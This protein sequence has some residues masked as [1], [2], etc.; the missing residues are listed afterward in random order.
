M[1]GSYWINKEERSMIAR[2]HTIDMKHR[3]SLEIAESI[4]RT[5]I[6]NDETIVH[7][8]IP[9]GSNDGC[10][11]VI[12]VD[13]DVVSAMFTYAG[14]SVRTMVLNFAS[15][16]HP[17]GRYL[18]GSSAQE[19][20]L[21]HSSTL[22][23]ILSYFRSTYY[24]WNKRNLNKGLYM[25]RALYSPDVIFER[26]HLIK[27]IDVVTCAAPNKRVAMD[28]CKVSESDNFTT[29]YSRIKFILDIAQIQS[30]QILILGAFGCG[31]FKQSPDE[32]AYIFKTLLLKY[33]CFSKVIFAIPARV[34]ST[35]L[36]IFQSYFNKNST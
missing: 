10:C 11:D 35:N 27:K 6:Y 31:V 8:N 5:V 28:Y 12:V 9:M 14:Q 26:D 15:Y 32:V 30:A 18:D 13:M 22:Y 21:C 33:N 4:G 23:N 29:L 16:K 34:N 19:E 25:N 24:D 36:E 1:N 17:G 2:T 20:C 7:N 3:Y